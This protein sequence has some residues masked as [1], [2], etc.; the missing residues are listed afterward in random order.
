MHFNSHF[1]PPGQHA[2]LSASKPHWGGYDDDKLARVYMASLAAKRGDELHKFAA[3][4]IRLRVKL[5]GPN[6]TLQKYV[7]DAIG[8]H[9][10]PEQILFY[11]ENAYGTADAICFRKGKLR[12]HDLKTG[13]T[14]ASV[15]QL[16]VYAAFFCLEYLENPFKIEINLRIYQ[17]E[18]VAEFIPDPDVIMHW[19][20][21]IKHK[22]KIIEAMKQEVES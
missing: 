8:F 9:M 10:T 17:N 4:A 20:E 6:K 19:M 16:E 5:A 18:E 2:F 15:H 3:D 14:P 21:S 7:N 12:I 22:H 11:S 1:I 13:F